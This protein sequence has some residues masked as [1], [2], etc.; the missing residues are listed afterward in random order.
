M[1]SPLHQWHPFWHWVS[2]I[3]FLFLFI[4]RT[5][6]RPGWAVIP[7]VISLN[8]YAFPLE[9]ED[10]QPLGKS[11]L[12]CPGLDYLH[13]AHSVFR[14]SWPFCA[15]K[16]SLQLLHSRGRASNWCSIGSHRHLWRHCCC[17]LISVFAIYYYIL[18]SSVASVVIF[19]TMIP[20]SIALVLTSL[21]FQAEI[22]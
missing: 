3:R 19:L 18:S 6:G 16:M 2:L 12:L 14:C 1:L 13:S 21:H 17:I 11:F 15:V 9:K 8:L 7:Q 10:L 5:K 22:E 4:G 20:G